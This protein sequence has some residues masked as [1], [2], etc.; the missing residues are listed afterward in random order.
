MQKPSA[1]M[2]APRAAVRELSNT[3]TTGWAKRRGST[4]IGCCGWLRQTSSGAAPRSWTRFSARFA[5]R[6]RNAT[7]V[8]PRPVAVW[9]VGTR[10]VWKESSV[11]NGRENATVNGPLQSVSNTYTSC[12]HPFRILSLRTEARIIVVR[13]SPLFC[14]RPRYRL[15]MQHKGVL[16]DAMHT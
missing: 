7:P 16:L 2:E 13:T 5:E 14:L 4:S 8:L 12:M 11:E 9:V 15:P 3:L 6:S 1:A 10:C